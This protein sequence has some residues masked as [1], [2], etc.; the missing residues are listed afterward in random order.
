MAHSGTTHEEYL[1][2]F[3]TMQK[4]VGIAAEVLITCKFEYS[5]YLAGK[6]LFTP[7][8]G[9]LGVTMGG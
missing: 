3:I 4:L 1:A 9:A 7:F 6:C 5:A 8:W 2:V